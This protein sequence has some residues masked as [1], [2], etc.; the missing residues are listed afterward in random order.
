MIR[1]R[2]S[3]LRSLPPSAAFVNLFVSGG[4]NGTIQPRRP[5]LGFDGSHLALRQCFAP[6]RSPADGEAAREP[7]GR[8][9]HPEPILC[10]PYVLT[11]EDAAGGLDVRAM[12]EPK[13]Q[14]QRALHWLP[15]ED[16]AEAQDA[17]D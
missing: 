16:L 10:C 12:T 11:Q 2:S 6:D 13:A 1:R 4:G 15:D 9:V 7:A 5:V 17:A 8:K 14:T 3:A